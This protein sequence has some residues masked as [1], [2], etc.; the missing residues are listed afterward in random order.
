MKK[1]NYMK[2]D[3][4]PGVRTVSQWQ[5]LEKEVFDSFP[6]DKQDKL[7]RLENLFHQV[8]EKLSKA[9]LNLAYL[10]EIEAEPEIIEQAQRT[11]RKLQKDRLKYDKAIK[12]N[13]ITKAYIKEHEIKFPAE[14][15]YVNV[16]LDRLV[17]TG[18]HIELDQV[19]N[20]L[21]PD[22]FTK[23]YVDTGRIADLSR[24]LY[25]NEAE[26]NLDFEKNPA[27][28][29]GYI[30]FD[31]NTAPDVYIFPYWNG[32]KPTLCIENLILYEWIDE[33][34]EEIKNG[35]LF[36]AIEAGQK[37]KAKKLVITERGTDKVIY[38]MEK[39]SRNIFKSLEEAD[40]NGQLRFV[41]DTIEDK[42]RGKQPL[43]VCSINFDTIEGEGV[44]KRLL[45]FDKLCYISVNALYSAGNDYI[46]IKQIYNVMTGKN[47]NPNAKDKEKIN[48][49]LTKMAAWV[50]ISNKEEIKR[51]YNYPPFE[52]KGALL[53]FDR[54]YFP[55]GVIINGQLTNSFIRILR[56]ANETEDDE[57]ALPLVKFAKERKQY[58]TLSSD[59]FGALS[60]T[61]DNL[62]IQDYLLTQIAFM[63]NP[64]KQINHKM[65]YDTICK[66]TRQTGKRKD[67]VKEKVKDIL[68]HLKKAKYI[69]AYTENGDGVTIIP[70]QP[71]KKIA[72]K[73][74]KK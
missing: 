28:Y 37:T 24:Q 32:D 57:R 50:T 66:E 3:Y 59:C 73:T 61:E 69:Y 45:E 22:D 18:N 15:Q 54:G 68:E 5:E 56:P 36:K 16:F 72:Q 70:K 52:Y 12:E 43:V 8:M 62:L 63:K 26:I 7:K 2:T 64:K 46:T 44:V 71:Q 14:L 20:Y 60:L 30:Y 23:K 9:R 34:G 49:S 21:P 1:F 33:Q 27:K 47:T 38:P 4:R 31:P 41:F 67:R 39:I 48:K 53:P 11:I 74:G 51:G 6:K 58:T 35:L 19:K 25:E 13:E 42:K 65:L 17:A 55:N 40:P 10:E 29:E